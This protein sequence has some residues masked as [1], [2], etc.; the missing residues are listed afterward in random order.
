MDM[1]VRSLKIDMTFI[2]FG[3]KMNSISR[4]TSWETPDVEGQIIMNLN[5]T[6]ISS[7]ESVPTRH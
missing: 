6:V 4:S 1:E 7:A 2:S 3:E 5:T